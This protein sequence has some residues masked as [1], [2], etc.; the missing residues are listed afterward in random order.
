MKNKIYKMWTVIKIKKNY[1]FNALKVNLK[2][3]LVSSPK[4]YSPKI[5]EQTI[6]GNKFQNKNCYILGSYLLVFHEKFKDKFYLNKLNFTKGV[7]IVV[8]GFEYSQK[9][10]N[11]FVEK[12]KKNENAKGYLIQ[13][14]LL[15][16][17]N[18]KIKFCSGP[19]INFAINLIEVQ[20]NK[21]S[22]LAGKYK[23]LVNKKNN[24]LVS[25]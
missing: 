2:K 1:N 7:D 4:I 16:N 19:F 21:I 20:K 23:I 13:N 8:Q 3:L 17:L 14:F 22:V 5:L 18:K 24:F 9:E 25:C 6:K 15:N 12:C 11:F 10:I